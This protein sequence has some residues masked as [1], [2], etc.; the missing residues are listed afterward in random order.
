[1]NPALIIA[2]LEL[3][4]KYGPQFVASILDACHKKDATLAD[5]ATILKTVKPYEAYNIPDTET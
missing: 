3:T 2:I 5:V 1:M 4:A